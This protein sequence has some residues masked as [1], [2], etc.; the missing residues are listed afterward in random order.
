MP[1]F[2]ELD[3]YD[4]PG[5]RA[6]RARNKSAWTGIKKFDV[7]GYMYCQILDVTKLDPSTIQLY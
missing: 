2:W 7:A 3:F 5:Q 6:G 1:R 4:K